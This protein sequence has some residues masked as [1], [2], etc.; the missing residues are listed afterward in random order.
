MLKVYGVDCL[1]FKESNFNDFLFASRKESKSERKDFAL[2][3]DSLFFQELEQLPSAC[4]PYAL[5]L[6]EGEQKWQTCSPEGVLIH[7]WYCGIKR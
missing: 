5:L 4:T 7:L 2:R 1:A 3:G 6:K